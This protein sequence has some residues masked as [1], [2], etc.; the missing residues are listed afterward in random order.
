MKKILAVGV[1]VLVAAIVIGV[2]ATQPGDKV[3]ADATP[4]S[5]AS[6]AQAPSGEA[7]AP[8]TDAAELSSAP[9]AKPAPH[10]PV[11]A[12]AEERAAQAAEPDVAGN[13][14][15]PAPSAEAG[16]DASN[17]MTAMKEAAQSG[18]YLFIF[19]YGERND[20][21]DAFR[22]SF[23]KAT[24]GI[25]DKAMATTVD[26]TSP[27]EIEIVQKFRLQA[28]PLPLVLAVAPNG[29]ITGNYQG[30]SSEKILRETMVSPAFQSVLKALQERKLV[31]LCIQNENTKSNVAAMDGVMEFKADA[32]FAQF[33]EV[34]SMDPADT[35]E[36]DFMEKLQVDSKTD[37]ALTVFLAPPGAVIAK[38]KGATKKDV[39]ASTLQ[40]AS[41]GGCGPSG[42]GPSGCN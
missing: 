40:A 14:D 23:E 29:A 31:F 32:R 13:E 21:T 34:V 26:V 2:A 4:A 19:F 15:A 25:S 22:E 16:N 38:F 10:T 12:Q 3:R 36:A 24:A 1:A 33:T 11:A 18:R 41:S 28:V 5:G 8:Q 20:Q 42:C 6:A 39:L 37:E 30:E 7:D 35:S 17:A 9:D 27:G